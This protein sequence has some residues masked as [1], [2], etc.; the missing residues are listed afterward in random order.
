MRSRC[1]PC[2]RWYNSFC[3]YGSGW[4]NS[5]TIQARILADT[6]TGQLKKTEGAPVTLDLEGK[7]VVVTG[8][9]HSAQHA[10]AEAVAE[11]GADVV[12][13]LRQWN[14]DANEEKVLPITQLEIPSQRPN[15][16]SPH[17][18]L[19]RQSMGRHK[20]YW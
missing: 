18:S 13:W 10:I 12:I 14:D 16:G 17:T 6:P 3:D 20:S 1:L 15:G 2:W 7:K 5:D 9:K 19:W 11:E 8:G 4:R